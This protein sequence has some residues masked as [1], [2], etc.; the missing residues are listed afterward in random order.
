MGNDT[1][2]QGPPD[3]PVE[4]W[5]W[6]S[7][8]DLKSARDALEDANYPDVFFHCQQAVEKR[9][10][11]AIARQRPEPPPRTHRLWRLSEICGLRPSDEQ[12]ELMELLTPLYADARYPEA[13]P[14]AVLDAAYA[15][16]AL[17]ETEEFI[18]WLDRQLRL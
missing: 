15:K 12:K 18:K 2:S 11:A 8:R 6:L 3:D 5:V 14:Q 16:R 17:A 13:M 9:L 4:S 10:K 1:G 7:N